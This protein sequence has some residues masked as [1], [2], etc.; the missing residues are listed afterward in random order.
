MPDPASSYM[1]GNAPQGASYGAP[2]VNFGALKDYPEDYFQ[3]QQRARTTALQNAFPNGLPKDAN[4]NPDVNQISATLSKLGGA[5]YAKGLVPFLM[6]AKIGQAGSDAING[7]DGQ[8]PQPTPPAAPSASSSVPGASGPANIR[9]GQSATP[10][11][12]QPKLSSMGTDNNGQD[13][14]RSVAT[15][16][17]GGRDV[18]SLIPRYATYMKV[19][20]DAPLTP[21]QVQQARTLMSPTAQA[22][23]PNQTS[24]QTGGGA[25]VNPVGGTSDSGAPVASNGPDGSTPQ[26]QN[27]APAA[28]AAPST[29]MT[30]VRVPGVPQGTDPNAF[31]DALDK[32]ATA[33]HA[34]AARTAAFEGGAPEAQSIE[35]QAKAFED[36]AGKIRDFLSS[37][38]QPTDA[39]K[40]AASGATAYNSV[41]DANI[42]SSTTKLAGVTGAANQY[43]G[44][45]RPKVQLAQAVLNDPRTYTG[46]GGDL[47]LMLNRAVSTV[48]PGQAAQ[49]Q[50][51]LTKVTA[52]SILSQINGLKDMMMEAGGASSSAGR[53]FQ[54]QVELMNK[55]SP[56]LTTTLQGNRAL[57][58]MERRTGEQAMAVRDMALQYLG[59]PDANGVPTKHKILDAGFDQQVA[60]YLKS[61][62]LFNKEELSNPALLGVPTAPSGITDT[63]KRAAWGNGMDLK[64]GDQ[65]RTPKGGYAYWGK[66]KQ[67]QAQ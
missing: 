65:F 44:D 50:E 29:S 52:S 36:R 49:L 3:G 22:T 38:Q 35:N 7:G 8:T 1:V 64:P 41:A 63:A 51:V 28:P 57:V 56:Q 21:A 37:S 40:N 6:R 19:D 54:Q 2:L 61:H 33:M 25:P 5:D 55:A 10:P 53:I 20:P 4:G 43:E 46:T 66:S 13:T 9:G 26:G 30:G 60:S 34:Q 31:A 11:P 59:P 62:P 48:G 24:D 45:L 18:S 23:Q 67:Q 12:G 17:F 14:L 42:K 15:E 39:M 58:E 16:S 27:G 32:R 47:R